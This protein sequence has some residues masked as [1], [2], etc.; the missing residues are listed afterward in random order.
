MT[1]REVAQTLREISQLL[2]IKGENAF[3]VRAYD[4]GAD[5]FDT[6]P[7]DPAAPGGLNELVKK[8]TLTELGGVGKAISD[9]V[10]EL[11]TTGRLRYLD[12]LRKEFP[13]GA[14][15][16][17]RIP[18]LGPRKAAM[19]IKELDVGS[20]TDLERA[21]REHRVRGLKGF[22]ERT[23]L[24]IQQGIE[25][26]KATQAR[27]PLYETRRLAEKLLER[28]RAAPGVTRV[29]IAGSVRRY[30]EPNADVDLVAAAAAPA[31]VMDRFAPTSE[32]GWG[33][34]PGPPPAPS[35]R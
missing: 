34:G 22:G 30:K 5:A 25:A 20:L 31:P 35:K 12:E 3:K 8:G 4:L 15:D 1:P 6:L 10:T 32:A 13:L 7:S 26:L 2:Q 27:R 21:V 19:L 16:L 28:V 18:G 9:K 14:L 11:V 33:V 17:M 24:Q 29:E 23:E